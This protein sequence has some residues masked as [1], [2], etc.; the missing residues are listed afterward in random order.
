MITPD[1][2]TE[3]LSMT[4]VHKELE[5]SVLR[6]IARRIAKSDF[7]VTDTAA[8]EIE[9]GQQAG[10]LF[11]E[12]T[13]AVSKETAKSTEEVKQIFKEAELEVLNY[14]EGVLKLAGIEPVKFKSLSPQMKS[15]Y[16]AALAGTTRE[17]VNLT[18]TTA[19]L[20]ETSFIN[21]CNI[22]HTKVASGIFTYQEAIREAIEQAAQYGTRVLYPSGATASLD[23]AVR[24]AVLSGVGKTA[25]TITE[26][27][28]N[29]FEVDL[30]ELS[31]HSG[32]RPK[33]AIWQ[34]RIVSRSGRAG[35]LS[36]TD[37][38][39][40]DVTGFCGANCS[41]DWFMFF[42]GASSRAYTDEELEAMQNATVTYNG[43]EM[44]EYKAREM[45]RAGERKIRSLKREL[46]CLDEGIKVS[47]DPEVIFELKQAFEKKAVKLKS[48]EASLADF[49]NQTGLKRDRFREQMFGTETE[50]GIKAWT[51]SVSSK[52][53]HSAQNH[54]DVWRKGI[55]AEN[56]PETLA[57]Y[58]N[59]KYNDKEEYSRFDKYKTA[60][61]KKEAHPLLGYESYRNCCLDIER[62]LMGITTP[63]GL[64]IKGYSSHFV[65]RTIGETD[66]ESQGK[67]PVSVESIKDALTNGTLGKLQKD[68]DGK[69]SLLHIGKDCMVSVNPDDG[70]L[71]QVNI[72]KR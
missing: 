65:C 71:V 3:L 22:A 47:N 64:K 31:A 19:A 23:V 27:K 58:Y 49:C 17:I 70:N 24:R 35:Y 60:V 32:A 20:S 11:D 9:M 6:D 10:L 38:G 52:A 2:L 28:A 57:K 50:N 12:I 48:R 7:T 41:H 54:Y 68:K 30:M 44:P 4:E 69:P 26:M 39:Y 55:G 46:V 18:K 14:D 62:E 45:Q 36:L 1:K 21:V 56:T 34:G 59:M 72:K 40:G 63:A 13:E 33:H 42:E 37:I 15:I 53:V 67:K 25:S 8:Y 43:E 66:R 61:N 16:T 5:E 51:K 29:E